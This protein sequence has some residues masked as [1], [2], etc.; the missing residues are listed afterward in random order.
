[1]QKVRAL[2]DADSV[3]RRTEFSTREQALDERERLLV[4][5]EQALDDRA[6]ALERDESAHH[7]EREGAFRGAL[8]QAK[9]EEALKEV[10]QNLLPDTDQ[11]ML[12]SAT[13]PE[14][15]KAA[16]MVPSPTRARS[17]I[18]NIPLPVPVNQPATSGTGTA[19]ASFRTG[20]IPP[21]MT[22]RTGS[23]P[24]FASPRSKPPMAQ[25]CSPRTM[26]CSPPVATVSASPQ[27]DDG[28]VRKVSSV[29]ERKGNL[30]TALSK[31]G[32]QAEDSVCNTSIASTPGRSSSV[33]VGACPSSK[34]VRRSLA[35]LLQE[36]E[37]RLVEL[38]SH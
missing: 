2:A 38:R 35:E 15:A 14:R 1:M 22:L 11:A 30:L 25:P 27:A 12:K 33:G 23:N 37:A 26:S 24:L 31:G 29:L 28:I 20:S 17:N 32:F 5:R 36:D 6:R 8:D 9:A 13:Q 34:V 3:V 4:E 10:D 18:P 19:P 21:S 16:L 7:I